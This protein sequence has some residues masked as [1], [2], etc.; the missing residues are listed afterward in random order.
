MLS[1]KIVTLH[2]FIDFIILLG[3]FLGVS[4]TYWDIQHHILSGRDSFWIEPH[5]LVYSGVMLIL[6]GS[7]VGLVY[8]AKIKDK[9]S[10]N[11][12]YAILVILLTSLI[13]IFFAWGDDIW[14]RIFGL[15]VTVWSPPHTALLL[16]GFL[17]GLGFIYFQRLYMHVAKLDKVKPL[18][19]DELKL[20]ALIAIA[21]VGFNVFIAEFEYFK[22]KT[23]SII[24]ATHPAFLRPT[25]IYLSLFV[26]IFIFLFTL[27]KSITN[28]K[29]VATRITIFYLVIRTL[30]SIFLTGWEHG[31]IIPFTLIIPALIFDELYSN[32]KKRLIID[33]II[34]GLVFYFIHIVYLKY[35]SVP[36]DFSIN[37]FSIFVIALASVLAI[38]PGFFIGNRINKIV[39][40][41]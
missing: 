34:T 23:I 29:F 24:P 20:E 38:Y 31:A 2:N 8:T 41:Q 26:F 21:L 13:Q 15:D 4:G 27:A 16:S 18:T 36:A 19:L 37:V 28:R 10:K 14:H 3:T 39:E 1:K 7:L 33:A 5:L 11:F 25:W 30:I 9:Q 22:L 32:R 12:F 6:L 40:N 17:I 35:L